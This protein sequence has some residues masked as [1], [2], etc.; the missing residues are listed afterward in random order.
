MRRVVCGMAVFVVVFFGAMLFAHAATLEEA[1]ALGEKAAAYV[2]ANGKDKAIAEFN[3][4]TGL[5]V[6]GSLY[7]VLQD[8][9]GVVLAN[10]GNTGLVGQNHFELKDPNG[11]YFVKESVE[12]A[13]KGSG[14]LEYSW[15]NPITKKVQPKKSWIQRVEGMDVYT[16]CGLFQ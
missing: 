4:P 1:K 11:K 15:V 8:F 9:K 5:W 6:K 10:G 14:W 3:N 7:V 2:K 13:K 12:I 16:N